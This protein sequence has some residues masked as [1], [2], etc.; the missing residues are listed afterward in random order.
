MEN[1]Q[2]KAQIS[3]TFKSDDLDPVNASDKATPMSSLAGSV[4]QPVRRAKNPRLTIE[5]MR[6]VACLAGV[7]LPGLSLQG[8]FIAGAVNLLQCVAFAILGIFASVTE[9]G[10]KSKL[11]SFAETLLF[12]ALFGCGVFYT[13][14]FARSR[15]IRDS[16]GRLAPHLVD[17]LERGA[18]GWSSF[19]VITSI[20]PAVGFVL[21]DVPLLFVED[22][23]Q[24]AFILILYLPMQIAPVLLGVFSCF[25]LAAPHVDAFKQTI[26]LAGDSDE[27]HLIIS[28]PMMTPPSA[29]NRAS[30]TTVS[31]DSERGSV[32][33]SLSFVKERLKEIDG[34]VKRDARIPTLFLI[35]PCF[36][37]FSMHLLFH[38]WI[39]W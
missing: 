5:T 16:D 21:K 36:I 19:F 11:Q 37:F 12:L 27:D 31:G 38:I 7:R 23:W 15:H 10:A 25:L 13:Q 8:H 14:W 29:S 30:R 9:Q 6:I 26:L 24:A 2:S 1:G 28:N 20:I 33:D 18:P 34:D 35:I 22:G 3:N 17:W 32:V 39:L 4:P